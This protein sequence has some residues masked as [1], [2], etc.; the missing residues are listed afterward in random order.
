MEAKRE[1]LTRLL[2]ALSAAER[3]VEKR[4]SLVHDS[5]RKRFP[6]LAEEDLKV[7]EQSAHFELGVSN[8]LLTLLRQEASWLQR[9]GVERKSEVRIR[10]TV[11]K[12]LLA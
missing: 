10:H 7:V 11:V 3:L 2:R 5:L 9:L 1:E 4:P 6:E 8:L 12:D